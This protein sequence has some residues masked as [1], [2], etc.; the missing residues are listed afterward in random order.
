MEKHESMRIYKVTYPHMAFFKNE[1]K[2]YV[3]KATTKH[4]TNANS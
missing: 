1:N 3:N 4:L 2:M